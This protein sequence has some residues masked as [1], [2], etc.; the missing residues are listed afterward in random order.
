MIIIIIMIIIMIIIIIMI[1]IITI[2]IITPFYNDKIVNFIA[3]FPNVK[4][5]QTTKKIIFLLCDQI[6][7]LRSL[8]Q[9]SYSIQYGD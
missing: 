5:S 9:D 2:I 7:V 8:C 4:M 1:M 6:Y 3:L